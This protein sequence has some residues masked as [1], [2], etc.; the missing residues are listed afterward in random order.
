MA[1]YVKLASILFKTAA[2][3]GAPDAHDIVLRETARTLDDLKGLGLDLVVFCEGVE[4]FAQT[5]RQAEQVDRPGPLLN[6]YSDFARDQR[7]HV[8]GSIKLR[9]DGCVYNSIAFFGRD[10][11]VLGRYHK[12]NLTSYGEIPAGLTS[13]RDATIVETDI[14]RLGGIVCFDLNFEDIRRQYRALKPDI[15]VFP[16]MYHGGFMQQLW[17][18]ECRAYF[19]SALPFIGGGILDPFGRP[20]ALTDCY[21]SVARARVNLDRVM[22]HLDLNRPKF[23]EIERKYADR[24]RI[25]IPPNLGAALIFSESEGFSA[26]DIVREFELELLDDYFERSLRLNDRNRQPPTRQATAKI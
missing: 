12:V 5:A 7:C 1:Q 23:P 19:I 20:V 14:G 21:T 25:D 4:A 24:V 22:V 9:E 16:S 6:L 18:Y 11:A 13:G 3:R 15:L 8:A 2:R 10:G 17:A 26:A